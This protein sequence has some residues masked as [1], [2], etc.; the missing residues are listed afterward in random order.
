MRL[1]RVLLL[2]ATVSIMIF[3]LVFTISCSGGEDGKNGKNGS[4][5]KVE[6]DWS[7][8]CD[9]REVGKL[10]GKAGEDGKPGTN[11]KNGKDGSGCWLGEKNE[12]GSYQILCGAS[13][14]NGELKGYLDGC[15]AK[16][17]GKWEVQL[18]CG[19]T[20]VNLCKNKL[21]DTEKQYCDAV[22]TIQT[23]SAAIYVTCG[24][25]EIDTRKQYCGFSELNQDEKTT[26]YNVCGLATSAQ[27]NAT[28]WN[29]EYCRFTSADPDEAIKSDELCDGEPL[30]KD[31]WK[32]EYCGY[33]SISATKKTVITGICDKKNLKPST[34]NV[35]Y[36]GPNERAFGQGYCAVTF[37]DRLTG[38]TSYSEQLCG[39]N[40][41]STGNKPNKDKWQDQY[42]GYTN[43]KSTTWDKVYKG[44]C[45]N[46]DELSC[47]KTNAAACNPN[48]SDPA[49]AGKEYC[50]Y[51]YADQFKTTNA[52]FCGT[53]KPN[54][55]KWSWDYCGWTATAKDVGGTIARA[56][57][58]GGMCGD[59][60]GAYDDDRFFGSNT[61]SYDSDGKPTNPD[62]T[63][64]DW[65]GYCQWDLSVDPQTTKLIAKD[66][67][68]IYSI[69]IENGTKKTINE[70]KWKGEYCLFNST[71]NTYTLKTDGCSDGGP[72]PDG[73]ATKYCGY[74]DATTKV[75]SLMDACDDKKK[76]N[77]KKYAKEYCGYADLTAI[78][79][80]SSKL[81][82]N[83][84]DSGE[85]PNGASATTIPAGYCAADESGYT[86]LADFCGTTGK[87][88]E[89]VWKNEYCWKDNKVASC[90]GGKTGLTS[91]FKSDTTA[92]ARCENPMCSPN[93]LGR[94]GS[95]TACS[96]LNTS[97]NLIDDAFVYDDGECK[98]QCAPGYNSTS[99][100]YNSLL[101]Y[102]TET[103]ECSALTSVLIGNKWLDIGTGTYEMSSSA[104][105]HLKCSANLATTTANATAA[106]VSQ[107]AALGLSVCTTTECTALGPDYE[108]STATDHCREKCSTSHLGGCSST[109][110][111][112]LST[113][114]ATYIWE[115][116]ACLLAVCDVEHPQ[117][118]NAT[119]CA[120]LPGYAATANDDSDRYTLN[121]NG[122]CQITKY[123]KC[124]NHATV[125][126]S[127]FGTITTGGPSTDWDYDDDATPRTC[128][129]EI[130]GTNLVAG[131][132]GARAT[133]V[134]AARVA[135]CAEGTVVTASGVLQTAC[136]SATVGDFTAGVKRAFTV[137][138]DGIGQCTSTKTNPDPGTGECTDVLGQ[139]AIGGTGATCTLVQD[140]VQADC[141][142]IGD[143]DTWV[144][145]GSC[146]TTTV[147]VTDKLQANCVSA[148]VA[149]GA[150]GTER[151][152]DS[153]HIKGGTCKANDV[154]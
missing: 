37:A 134:D 139:S 136:V 19:S 140:L 129:I 20:S 27:P 38:K 41:S 8:T 78:T 115:N 84:C 142:G 44:W 50:A 137:N 101:N 42:C 47:S 5:C 111:A 72:N 86:S 147:T 75:T 63:V 149:Q 82:S 25:V 141:D 85:E 93:Q 95:S 104:P 36:Q 48:Q 6:D 74:A 98:K 144:A 51:T 4:V 23:L 132:C 117:Y 65:A 16:D 59:G 1:N 3:A 7:I 126:G 124:M 55:S 66:E 54:S 13:G 12:F 31:S 62:L 2:A 143:T 121:T 10:E 99:T 130:E 151:S 9:G 17:I 71:S 61:P 152:W 100:G 107:L 110:C 92:W 30:N 116:N 76:P 138:T 29:D 127:G 11:G 148:T 60:K 103:S 112:A 77:E 102:C 73:V 32:T 125:S 79:N 119:Q 114:T 153:T 43:D 105:C 35:Y 94:C 88:N 69:C 145:K 83:K 46:A 22:G 33:K 64:T 45:D 24:D 109:E 106:E 58:S 70:G 34:D 49:K 15:V 122:V 128:E 67:T 52:S 118:C 123:G 135:V 68:D 57:Y 97:Y 120:A 154:P 80:G 53:N 150:S 131:N 108:W 87:P 26:V 39:G 14:S 21:F 56:V 146:R 89:N 133:W 81:Y 28:A 91:A 18:N 90:P 96:A 113:S 40:A